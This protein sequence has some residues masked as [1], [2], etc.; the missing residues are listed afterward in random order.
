[1]G[2]LGEARGLTTSEIELNEKTLWFFF[3]LVSS[4]AAGFV[5]SLADELLLRAFDSA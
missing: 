2:F 3:V 1:M 4:A 5:L